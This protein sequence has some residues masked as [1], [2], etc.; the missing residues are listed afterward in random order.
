MLIPTVGPVT[1]DCQPK[2][3]GHCFPENAEKLLGS[4][5]L[6]PYRKHHIVKRCLSKQWGQLDDR[7]NHGPVQQLTNTHPHT[8]AHALTQAHTHTHIHAHVL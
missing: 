5:F 2:I 6:V 3:A 4:T 8:Q 7:K 1:A